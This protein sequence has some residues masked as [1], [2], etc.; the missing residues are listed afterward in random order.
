M[1]IKQH[2]EYLKTSHL[3]QRATVVMNN[4]SNITASGNVLRNSICIALFGYCTIQCNIAISEQF[5][6]FV[7]AIDLHGGNGFSMLGERFLDAS[8]NTV[9]DAGDIN[10]DGFNDVLIAAPFADNE[11]NGDLVGRTYVIYGTSELFDR[12]TDLDSIDG[13][14]GFVIEGDTP[15]ILSGM[16]LSTAGDFNGDGFDDILIGAPEASPFNR[17]FAGSTYLIFGSPASPAPVLLLGNLNSSLGL[18]IDGAAPLDRSGTS[19]SDAG[20]VNGDG[21]DDIIIGAP[22]A[23]PG[24]KQRAGSTYVIYGSNSPNRSS[25]DLS[26]IAPTDGF[27]IDGAFAYDSSGYSVGG[28][29]D[30]N[31]D[32]FYDL[33][34][35]APSASPNGMTRAGSCYIIFGHGLLYFTPIDLSNI[36]SSTGIRFDGISMFDA[37]GKS[38]SGLQDFNSDGYDDLIFGAP[39]ADASLINAGS[40]YVIFGQ[41]SFPFDNFP[42]VDLDSSIGFKLNGISENSQSGFSVSDAGDINADGFTDLITGAPFN[43]PGIAQGISFV[44]FGSN[45]PLSAE[46]SLYDLDGRNG[47]IFGNE[48]IGNGADPGHSVSSAGDFNGDNIDDIIIGSPSFSINDEIN[49]IPSIGISH[50]IYG[51]NVDLLFSDGYEDTL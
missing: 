28:H 50:V 11:T 46:I 17:S 32:G 14:N 13:S 42:L 6:D 40:T 26:A 25:V 1:K 49:F 9:S 20:D 4:H 51:K 35:G 10:G 48:F 21:F 39:F 45:L 7:Q 44:F 18:R 31:G 43:A 30:I 19:I 5:P 38:V 16:S 27:R 36:N 15:F 41:S 3:S 47:F 29:V 34:I 24:D 33:I 8:G 23:D 2:Y 22:N 37:T 12:I